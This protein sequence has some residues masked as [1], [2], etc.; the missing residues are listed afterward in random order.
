MSCDSAKKTLKWRIWSLSAGTFGQSESWS[1]HISSSW[2][3]PA[4][5]YEILI[6]P[7][8]LPEHAILNLKSD[9]SD[10]T[11][12]QRTELKVSCGTSEMII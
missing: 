5:P 9:K 8:S 12:D 3:H 4:V 10:K 7:L 2:K 11:E 6:D 1:V